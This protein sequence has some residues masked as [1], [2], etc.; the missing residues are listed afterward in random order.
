MEELS[1]Q[2]EKVTS[3]TYKHLYRHIKQIKNGSSMHD[4]QTN[5]ILIE[6]GEKSLY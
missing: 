5:N 6:Q 4:L 1:K 3:K 2:K